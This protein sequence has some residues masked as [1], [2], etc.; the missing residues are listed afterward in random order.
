[1]QRLI[2]F[3]AC[4]CL[5]ACGDAATTTVGTTTTITS[6]AS[7]P[8]VAV[9]ANGNG[10]AAWSAFVNGHY[11]IQARML[12]G[13]NGATIISN[14][15][16]DTSFPQVAFDSLGNAIAVWAQYVNARSD[17]WACR[18]SSSTGSW[19][20]PV[21]ISAA[22]AVADA[23]YPDVGVDSAGNAVATWYQGNGTTNHFD[24]H[25]SRFTATSGTW[26]S[27]AIMND[28]NF[29]AYRCRVG[30]NGS[31]KVI[32]VWSQSQSDGSV[33][34]APQDIWVRNGTTSGTWGS[35][36]K[37]N[38]LSGA[39]HDVYGQAAVALDNSGNGLVLWVQ[40]AP[41]SPYVIHAA[42]FEA[43]GSVWHPSTVITSTADNNCY[44]P[45]LAI[46]ATGDAIAVWHQQTT[47]GVFTA[48]NRYTSG[49]G[50]GTS[51][52]VSGT[53]ELADTGAVNQDVAIDAQ[54]N[55]TVIWA[56]QTLATPTLAIYTNTFTINSGWGTPRLAGTAPV[57]VGEGFAAVGAAASPAGQVYLVWGLDY[58]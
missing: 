25:T 36:S 35:P 53:F 10:L 4:L 29:S 12:N 47:A 23:G 49:S 32:L 37:V 43:A 41:N 22:D 33:S 19:G 27:P 7:D 58:Y 48:A 2:L 18:Y 15:S 50:W 45:R 20:A 38:S 16:G 34:N 40:T 30:V 24:V 11:Q 5:C 56:E 39:V 52:S 6:V 17:I 31:G 26:S 8:D 46:T 13:G 14:G 54:G 51:V 42:R 44:G 57:A 9:D 3:I 1:M 55:A 28:L 21:M